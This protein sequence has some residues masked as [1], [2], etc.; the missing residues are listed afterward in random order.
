MTPR[1]ITLRATIPLVINVFNQHHY[2]QRMVTQFSENGFRNIVILDNNSSYPPLLAYYQELA[3]QR[4][5]NVIYYNANRGPHYF[6]LHDLHTHL[7]EST[8]FLY[9]DPDLAWTELSPSFLSTLFE[10]SHRHKIF[11][12]GCALTL[13]TDETLKPE[14]PL[15]NFNNRTY[16][17]PQWEAQ[18][19]QNPLEPNVYSAPIDTT[20]HLFNPAYFVQG[21]ALITGARVAGPGMEAIHLPWFRSDTCPD[22]ER[23]FYRSL[24]KHSSWQT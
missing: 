19:W 15:F 14:F 23:A 22:E 9:S 1:E 13:P 17:V 20:M 6:F 5:A 11:K 12:V 10:L 24:T 21:N 16:T 7:F 18:F 2:L 4:T 8:P 3:A